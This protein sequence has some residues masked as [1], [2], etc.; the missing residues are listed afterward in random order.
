MGKSMTEEWEKLKLTIQSFLAAPAEDR[1]AQNVRVAALKA[2]KKHGLV[3]AHDEDVLL[4]GAQKRAARVI[5]DFTVLAVHKD[6]E[7]DERAPSINMGIQCRTTASGRTVCEAK[8]FRP[9]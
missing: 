2:L 1:V 7:K 5:H 9:L 3:V 8:P 4:T 6:A